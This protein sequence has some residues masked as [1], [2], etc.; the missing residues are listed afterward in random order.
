[1]HCA[2]SYDQRRL[3]RFVS[4]FLN[5][6]LVRANAKSDDRHSERVSNYFTEEP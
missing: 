2:C 6:L 5:G 4:G 3:Q 1:M